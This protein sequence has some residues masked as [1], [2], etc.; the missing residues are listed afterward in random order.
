VLVVF[1]PVQ[2]I[3]VTA[4][5]VHDPTSPGGNVGSKATLGDMSGLEVGFL[6]WFG[7]VWFGLVWFGLV[8]HESRMLMTSL[9]LW[10]VEGERVGYG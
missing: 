10:L 7:L 1:S 5:Q 4:S 3:V 8:R 6:A 9:Q 2:R